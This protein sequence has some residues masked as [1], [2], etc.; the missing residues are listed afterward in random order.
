MP[1][2][3]GNHVS[4]CLELDGATIP[5]TPESN[6]VQMVTNT[7]PAPRSESP[8]EVVI[9]APIT[10]SVALPGSTEQTQPHEKQTSTSAQNHEGL[11]VASG[12]EVREQQPRS[13]PEEEELARLR[14]EQAKIQEERERLARL[15]ILTQEEER[16]T[17]R[18][19]ELANQ[20]HRKK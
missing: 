3:D 9:S 16:I 1:E 14:E 8:D 5:E 12:M 2:L 19:E 20:K 15:Q 18:I 7:S 10:D 6:A 17:R 4:P 11:A 13:V